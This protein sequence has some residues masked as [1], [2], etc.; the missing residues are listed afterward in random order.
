MQCTPM[1]GRL[2]VATILH[3]WRARKAWVP[4]HIAMKSSRLGSLLH[5]HEALSCAACLPAMFVPYVRPGWRSNESHSSLSRLGDPCTSRS[6]SAAGGA[7]PSSS[8]LGLH[9][10]HD[11]EGQGPV[12]TAQAHSAQACIAH[13]GGTHTI[14]LP[15]WE[16][17]QHS[18][19]MTESQPGHAQALRQPAP[20][21]AAMREEYSSGGCCHWGGM[22]WDRKHQ[23]NMIKSPN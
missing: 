8:G 18:P 9:K 14:S 3:L 15:L 4:F 6:P 5:L 23:C 22:P 13:A 20:N 11:L 12:P 17:P 16:S 19:S 10:G 7:R 2:N 1:L 21:E